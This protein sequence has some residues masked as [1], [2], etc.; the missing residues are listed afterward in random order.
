M[1]SDAEILNSNILIAD[2]YY[3]NVLLLE[4]MLHGAGYTCVASTI[5]PYK[6]LELHRNNRY[7]L[8]LLDLQMPGLDGFLLMEGLKK[9]EEDSYLPVIAIT[10]QPSY[11]LRALAAGAIDFVAKP[12]D[13]GEVQVR[14]YNMLKVR[15]LYKKLENTNKVLE[16][17]LLER[18]AELAASER[19]L[20]QLTSQS[21][22][23]PWEPQ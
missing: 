12:F 2:D 6:V 7:D 14:I 1:V 17:T 8:I 23:P 19:R 13:L 11:K 3:T 20:N 4:K 21:P 22:N 5:D 10:A 16:Q 18:T 9:I 15:L